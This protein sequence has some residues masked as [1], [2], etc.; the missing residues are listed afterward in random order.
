MEIK[1]LKTGYAGKIIPYG[2]AHHG[3]YMVNHFYKVVEKAAQYHICLD[4]HESIKPT[5]LDR[6]WPNLM[7]QEA[8]RGNEWNGGYK[9]TPPNLTTILPFTRYIAG[10]ADYTPGIF[11]TKHTPEKGKR[12]VTTR[13][14]QMALI[15]VFFSPMA[16]VSDDIENYENESEFKFMEE[17]PSIWN[18][19]KVL[20]CQIG[21][22]VSVA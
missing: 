9:L 17:V 20:N 6:T 2:Y 12:L 3:Q 4:V 5:G 14:H 16:M 15:V 21:Q 7:S 1:Y 18:Q 22:Y 11:N 10:P 13:A 8:I 19:T